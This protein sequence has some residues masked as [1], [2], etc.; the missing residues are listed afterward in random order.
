MTPTKRRV[1]SGHGS[2]GRGEVIAIEAEE[3]AKD[4]SGISSDREGS[5]NVNIHVK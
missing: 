2:S 3:K 4:R 1:R 5:W